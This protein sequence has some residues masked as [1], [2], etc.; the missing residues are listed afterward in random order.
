M[1][2]N[3]TSL[4]STKEL[5]LYE[6]HLSICLRTNGLSFSIL[7][8]K[9]T[10]LTAGDVEMNFATN[11]SQLSNEIKALLDELQISPFD[12]SSST[13][14]VPSEQ[15]VWVPESL[16]TEGNERQYLSLLTDIKM[17]M[18]VY[19]DYHPLIKA[20]IVYTAD[21]T[22]VTAFK[23]AIPNIYITCQHAMMV[24]ETLL[25]R[26]QSHPLVLL[27]LR[28]N[29]VDVA[30]YNTDGFLLGNSYSF[31]DNNELLYTALNVMKQFNLETPD[32]ELLICGDVDR[33]IYGALVNYFPN[34]DLYTG[35]PISFLNPE[36]Y[37]AYRHALILNY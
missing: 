24:N 29:K 4:I 8:P 26:A 15:A 16:Y 12:F 31:A 3:I 11:F 35:K 37:P 21:S 20:Y 36:Q 23:A 1:A 32:M 34:V 28:G 33:D 30:A 14:V 2:Y 18:G 22:M 5:A 7:S 25:Q 6:K 13:L 9:G 17:G 19:S 27:N 10:L